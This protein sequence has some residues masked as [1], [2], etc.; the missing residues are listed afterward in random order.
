MAFEIA[1]PPKI[2]VERAGLVYPHSGFALA[3]LSLEL[4]PGSFTCLLG[5]NGS[6]KSTLLGLLSGRLKAQSGR[7]LWDGR[8]A[9]QIDPK[10]RARTVAC[11]SQVEPFGVPFRVRDIVMMG[12]YP[13]Q[14][15]WPFDGE[16]DVEVAAWAMREMEVFDFADRLLEDLSSGERQRVYIARALAQEAGVLLLDEPAANFDLEHQVDLYALLHRLRRERKM[17]V[18]TVSHELTVATQGATQAVLL[19]SGRIAF[20]GDPDVALTEK[21]LSSVFGVDVAVLI[22]PATNERVFHPR[23][24]R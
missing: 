10:L 6:G 12:R 5:P 9:D 7:V 21:N 14:G 4:P 18:V 16:K 2:T 22:D 20:A 23:V 24:R 19:K 1:L 8:A 13:H 17:T 11:V 15:F 3:D